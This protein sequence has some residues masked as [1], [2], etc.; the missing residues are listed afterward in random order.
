M[1]KLSYW[2]NLEDFFAGWIPHVDQSVEDDEFDV[3]VTDFDDEVDIAAG[4]SFDGSWGRRQ[5]DQRPCRLVPHGRT[6]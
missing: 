3:V 4:D 1:G 2:P 5:S 6:V